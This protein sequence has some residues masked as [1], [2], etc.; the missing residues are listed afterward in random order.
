MEIRFH[1]MHGTLNDFVVFDDLEGKIR[2]T[3]EQVTRLCDRRAGIGADGV[4]AI[5][6]SDSADFFMDYVNADGSL[7]E[8]CGN[9]I[10]CL[11]KYAHDNGLTE[12]TTLRV[13]TRG[14]VKTLELSMGPDGHTHRVRVDMGSPIFDPARIPVNVEL[15]GGPV[16]DHPLEAGGRIFQASMVSMGNPHCVIVEQN[17]VES[18]PE[19]YGSIIEKHPLFPAKTNVEF[20]K[21]LSRNRLFMRVWERGSGETLSCGTGACASAV[22]ANLKGLVED[23]VTV[24]L[25]GGDLEIS[26]KGNQSSVVMSGEATFVYKGNITI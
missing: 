1:K 16:I 11:A 20:V 9:G 25:R 4:I 10:R 21:V 7:A 14:G 24:E 23:T 26:W 19:L 13:E 17:N 18:L 8:M 3:T 5:R 6:P 2:L 12:K 15:S 22:V